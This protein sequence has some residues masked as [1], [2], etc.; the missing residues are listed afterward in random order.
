MEAVEIDRPPAGTACAICKACGHFCPGKLYSADGE[1][2][3]CEDC[4]AGTSC[5]QAMARK[6]LDDIV[7]HSI[8]PRLDTPSGPVRSIPIPQRPE[9]LLLTK[10]IELVSRELEAGADSL[11]ETAGDVDDEGLRDCAAENRK[12]ATAIRENHPAWMGF[13]YSAPS[14]SIYEKSLERARS[15]L[16]IIRYE[17]ERLHERETALAAIETALAS[18]IQAEESTRV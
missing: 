18:N 14:E 1:T 9:N 8:V 16:K 12:I 5:P 11:E 4:R 13:A 3:I 6:S 17:L 2:A 10:A 15:E 7:E